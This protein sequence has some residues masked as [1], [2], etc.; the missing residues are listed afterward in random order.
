MSEYDLDKD[1]PPP[2]KKHPAL[3]GYAERD[4][5]EGWVWYSFEQEEEKE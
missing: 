4:D 1:Y 2:G 5:Q 3:I